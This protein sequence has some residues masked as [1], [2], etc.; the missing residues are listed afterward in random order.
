M[1][2]SEE[3]ER[4]ARFWREAPKMRH[5]DRYGGKK[6]DLLPWELP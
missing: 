5:D 6:Y 4:K 3:L 2:K 1:G